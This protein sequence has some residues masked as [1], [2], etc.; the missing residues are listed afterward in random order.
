MKKLNTYQQL[1]QYDQTRAG[2]PGEHWLTLGLGLSAWW[3]TRRNPSF[4]VRTAGLGVGT[5]LVSRAA[6]GRDGLTKVLRFL[7]IGR[8]V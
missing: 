4:I 5:A 3:L 1:K 8:R 6:S 2:V 7:P